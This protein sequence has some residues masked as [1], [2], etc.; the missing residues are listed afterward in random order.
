M[1]Y[2]SAP[3]VSHH[4]SVAG[5]TAHVAAS[6][7]YAPQR[8]TPLVD[9]YVLHVLSL[10][11]PTRP[12]SLVNKLSGGA[13]CEP[14]PALF[15]AIIGESLDAA[16]LS[17]GLVT[18]YPAN[19]DSPAPWRGISLHAAHDG[20]PHRISVPAGSLLRVERLGL[21]LA[22]DWSATALARELETA[23][24]VG[25]GPDAASVGDGARYGWAIE[26]NGRI[27][28]LR[29]GMAL[30]T[31]PTSERAKLVVA[32]RT[33]ALARVACDSALASPLGARRWLAGH[34]L[35]AVIID[36]P[37]QDGP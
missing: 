31:A 9:R 18:P 32:A 25:V 7:A 22:C 24:L 2:D 8:L 14:I 21:A 11:D 29:P 12:D 35:S 19:T 13:E 36:A 17:G 37:A 26:V 4:W 1:S 3:P 5:L 16:E 20:L 10:V 34:D 27:L 28:Q 33:C 15:A 6:G 30:A 23:V